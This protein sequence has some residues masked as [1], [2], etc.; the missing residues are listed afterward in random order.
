MP[1][2]TT[3]VKPAL[4]LRHKNVGVY[5]TYKCDD[6]E[7][8]LANFFTLGQNFSESSGE[9]FDVRELPDYEALVGSK[10]PS[11]LTEDNF[12]LLEASPGYNKA[13]VAWEDW[14][15]L[16]EKRIAAVI[17]RAIETGALEAIA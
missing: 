3:W 8:P 11:Y 17:R 9:C 7:D 1:Y 5:R 14:H 15:D 10:Q 12:P 16:F 2:Q 13:K 6:I 4:F